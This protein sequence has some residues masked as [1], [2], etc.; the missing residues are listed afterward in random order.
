VALSVINQGAM[1]FQGQIDLGM[2][3]MCAMNFIVPFI[4]LNVALLMSV[5]LPKRG[6]R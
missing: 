6:T 3:A 2:C 5:R 4:A 1:L